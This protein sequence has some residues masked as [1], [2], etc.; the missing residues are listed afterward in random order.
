MKRVI[1]LCLLLLSVFTYAQDANYVLKGRVDHPAFNGQTIYL[2]KIGADYRSLVRIDSTI[3]E[4][5]EF[6]F[7]EKIGDNLGEA[8]FI[9]ASLQTKGSVGLFIVEP[10]TIEVLLRTGNKIKIGGTPLNDEFNRYMDAQFALQEKYYAL[11]TK[12]ESGEELSSREMNKLSEEF[13]EEYSSLLFNIVDANIENSLGEFLF[14]TGVPYLGWDDVL[15]LMSKARP[16]FRKSDLG[17]QMI[18]YY[19]MEQ[20]R[21]KGA[22]YQDFK[23]SNP[24][25]SVVALSDYVGKDKIVLVDFWASWCGPCIK[26]MPNI[27]KVYERFKD[28]GFE[29]VGVSLDDNAD[30]WKAAIKRLNMTWPQMSDLKGW[31]SEAGKLYD[32]GSIPFTLLIGKDGKI[33]ANSL[34]AEELTRVLENLLEE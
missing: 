15:F 3:V 14:V 33:I 26:E 19:T 34:N 21:G 16:E 1:G 29:I 12:G 32:V 27:V 17:Q 6:S 31:K 30:S 25:G 9:S 10:D 2:D 11:R 28:K 18:A 20:K 13:G 8:R 24:Q 23:L 5:N 22:I 4:N 7:S